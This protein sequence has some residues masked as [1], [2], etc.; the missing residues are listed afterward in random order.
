VFA[1]GLLACASLFAQTPPVDPALQPVI[2]DPQLPRILLIGDSISMGYT[3]LVR[4]ALAGKANVHHPQE[5]CE[6]T[7]R[8]LAHLDDWVGAKKWDVIHFNFGLHDLKY[9]DS[10]GKMVRPDTGKQVRG[11]E[12]Y[13]ENLRRLV[14]RLKTTGAK[15]VWGSTTPVP[16]GSNGRVPG[17]EV[18]YNEAAARVT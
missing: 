2:D 7:G 9:I 1:C 18:K 17:D 11:V 12:A 6:D 10:A 13:E 15:L 3:P 5:N 4:E 8:G 14:A 16:A